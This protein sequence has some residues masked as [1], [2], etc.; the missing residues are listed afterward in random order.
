MYNLKF[1]KMD[2]TNQ[3]RSPGVS[4]EIS[5][6]G[7]R[8]YVGRYHHC[9]RIGVRNLNIATSHDVVGL[10]RVDQR[11]L[12]IQDSGNQSRFTIGFEIEKNRFHRNAVRE[13]PLLAGFEND[14]S[15]GVE[16]VTNI[17]PLVAPSVWRNKVFNMFTEAEKIIDDRFSPSN[18]DCGGHTTIRVEGMTSDE[19]MKRMRKLTYEEFRELLWPEFCENGETED[20]CVIAYGWYLR[21]RESVRW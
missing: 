18:S 3:M 16:G 4:Y 6:N 15:C 5:G 14:S 21:G 17:L 8:A 12:I 13:Y 10:P 1:K 19:L 20:E 11:N 9:Q 2:L 7:D